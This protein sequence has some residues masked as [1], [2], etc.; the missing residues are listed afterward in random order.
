MKREDLARVLADKEHVSRAAARDTLDA[1]I[2]E[3]LTHLREGQAAEMP[4]VGRLISPIP[5]KSRDSKGTESVGVK[6]LPKAP[7]QKS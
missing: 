5:E 1:I 4:G 3:I 6:K 7:T 2:H